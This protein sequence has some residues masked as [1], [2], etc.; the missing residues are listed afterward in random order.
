MGDSH[1][2]A[3]LHSA[4]DLLGSARTSACI[5]VLLAEQGEVSETL[6]F[7][8]EE[9]ALLILQQLFTLGVGWH[10]EVSAL[11]TTIPNQSILKEKMSPCGCGG[12]GD[13]RLWIWSV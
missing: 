4:S 5:S 2:T 9:T 3:C 12:G 8:F 7:F 13:V 11:L 6:S 1:W 10:F